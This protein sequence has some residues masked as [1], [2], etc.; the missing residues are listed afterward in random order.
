ML[1]PISN[2]NRKSST[3]PDTNISAHSSRSCGGLHLSSQRLVFCDFREDSM[4]QLARSFIERDFQ[5]FPVEHFDNIFVVTMTQYL[6]DTFNIAFP[7]PEI[8]NGLAETLSQNGKTQLHIAETEKYAHVTYFFNCLNNKPCDSETDVFIESRRENLENPEMRV[9]DIAERVITNINENLYDFFIINFANADVISH[10]GNFEA[11]VK[12]VEAV[13]KAIGQLVQAILEHEGIVV[14]TSDHGNAESM[15][16]QSSGERETK[17][18]DNPVP[19]YLVGKKFQRKRTE[20]EVTKSMSQANGLLSDIAP[21]ILE[22]MEIDKP[23]EM[24]GES[25]LK[26]LNPNF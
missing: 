8:K 10:S 23:A 18:N 12:G 25:L 19:L 15:L 7:P 9:L 17:H 4:R 11:T 14:I 24:T 2:F 3:S 20:E 26:I 5:I 22:L 1:Q 13:D 6:V 21:T 16:Y